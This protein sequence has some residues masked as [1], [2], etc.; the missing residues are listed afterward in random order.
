M[1]KILKKKSILKTKL[2]NIE[3]ADI[4][5]GDKV[6][7]YEIISGNGKGA[8]LVVPIIED[9]VIFIRE[10][11]A[12]VDDYMITLPKGSIDDDEDM[13]HAA[14]RE[15][16]E[17][18]GYKS[19]NIKFIKKIYLAPGYID[20]ITYIMSA[21]DLQPSKL[22]GDEPEKLEQIHVHKSNINMFLEKSEIIDSRV[23]A[24]LN[25]IHYND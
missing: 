12:A 22:I 9:K 3:Q 5:F 6:L 25:H 15:L 10:Y 16:Q 21:K 17:E 13:H 24:A 19:D 2:F 23:Y 1:S 14:N 11:A 8:V 4:R 18:I 20:H 7:K